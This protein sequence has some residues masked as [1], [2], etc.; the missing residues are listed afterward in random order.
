MSSSDP[1][2]IT[3][4]LLFHHTVPNLVGDVTQVVTKEM[5]SIFFPIY[6]TRVD[7]IVKVLHWPSVMASI[8]KKDLGGEDGLGSAKVQALE[9]AMCYTALCTMTD[10]ESASSFACKK[11]IL[12][13]QLRAAAELQISTAR[14]LEQPD[15]T[16]LQAF[17]I[18]LVSKASSSEGQKLT[19]RQ[20]GLRCSTT[21]ASAWSLLSL[22]VRIGTALGLGSEDPSKFSIFDLEI[23]RRVWSSIG[24]LD[25]QLALDRGAPALLSSEELQ[26]TPLNVNDSELY[27]NCPPLVERAGFTDMSFASMTHR[28]SLCQKTME[29]IPPDTDD[30]WDRWK[31]KLAVI[32][33]FEAYGLLQ[34]SGIDA[35][36]PPIQ[37]FAQAVAGGS[38]ANIKLM[39]RRPPH[40]NR[41]TRIPPWDDYDV[42]KS[43]TWILERSLFKQANSEFT[44]WAWFTW[45]KWYA[46]A[47]L[48]AE[49][50]G[51]IKGPEADRS[52]VVAQ[53]IFIEYAQVVA[54]SQSGMLWRPIVKLMRRVQKLRGSTVDGMSNLLASPASGM[55]QP[56]TNRS[57]INHNSFANL[58]I[59][60]QP[61][62]QGPAIALDPYTPIPTMIQSSDI[63][64]DLVNNERD[65][66]LGVDFFP[67]DDLSWAHWDNFLEDM[68]NPASFDWA[69]DWQN[70]V[71]LQP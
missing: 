71:P 24:L 32:D 51:P 31:E 41:Q 38:L 26:K 61:I 60:Q 44:P 59:N 5:K 48:L 68:N 55:E 28:A 45:V 64:Y 58:N 29:E 47:V 9:S 11:D 12:R 17:L 52:Y 39:T 18:Y 2:A 54:D 3:G 27:P 67:S 35:W 14:L 42:M 53:K 40:R 1:N 21:H 62:P 43:T 20:L 7:C 37:R 66:A 36:S 50:C 69:M 65:Q 70:N 25:A 15:L 23:R 46:L 8:E 22:A 49:L 34:F 4:T 6:K 10:E 13:E 16:V 33:K 30:S 19:R 57:G 63:T 56:T